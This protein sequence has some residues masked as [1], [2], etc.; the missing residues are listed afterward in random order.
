M[1]GHSAWVGAGV[2][3]GVRGGGEIYI[4]VCAQRKK[5]S[6]LSE[7]AHSVQTVATLTTT[8]SWFPPSKLIK[9]NMIRKKKRK[10]KLCG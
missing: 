8:T 2:G 10:R 6:E 9:H 5:P 1:H 4:F 3:G 7:R